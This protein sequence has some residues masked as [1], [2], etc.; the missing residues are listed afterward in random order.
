MK[1]QNEFVIYSREK[2]KFIPIVDFVAFAISTI[3]HIY[4]FNVTSI[5]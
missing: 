5:K 1:S 2:S 3:K 4:V